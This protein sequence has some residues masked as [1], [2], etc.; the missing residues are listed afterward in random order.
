M[1]PERYR[2]IQDKLSY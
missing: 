1:Q 2:C